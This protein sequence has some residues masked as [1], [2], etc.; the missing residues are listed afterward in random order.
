MPKPPLKE[1]FAQLAR[2]LIETLI[3]GHKEY[4]PDLSY[5]ESHSDM[6]GAVR[7]LL[8]K[9]EVKL[10]P[11]PLDRH[12]ILEPP[13]MCPVCWKETS[14]EVKMLRVGDRELYA[15]PDCVTFLGERE[16]KV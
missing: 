4:R 5:P 8:R 11:V 2:D 13:P 9:Y 14:S 15:H 6:Q 10:R 1:P 12:E 7:A 16:N 3:A